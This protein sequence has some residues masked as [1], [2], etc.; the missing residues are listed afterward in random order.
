MRSFRLIG[1]RS[2]PIVMAG[3]L[4]FDPVPGSTACGLAGAKAWVERAKALATES[5]GPHVVK[6]YRRNGSGARPAVGPLGWVV[7][8]GTWRH[9]AAG[10]D[11]NEALLARLGERGPGVLDELDGC[12]AVAWWDRASGTLTVAPDHF[13]RLHVYGAE[14]PEGTYIGTSPVA[15]ARAARSVDPD[16]VA[17]WEMLATGVIYEDRSP[18]AGVKRLLGTHRYR[19]RDGRS[20]GADD[21]PLLP[22]REPGPS[23]SVAD[24]ADACREAVFEWFDRGTRFLPDL[25]GGMDSRL[26]AG[27]QLGAGLA[28]DVTVTG[29]PEEPDARVAGDLARRLGLNLRRVPRA[30][31]AHAQ[32]SWDAVLRAASRVEGTYDAAEYAAIAAV[33]EP[34]SAIGEF[35]VNGSGGEVYRN[36]WWDERHVGRT[37]GDAVGE[38][39]RRFAAAAIAPR[40]AEPRDA[41]RHFR[42]VLARTLEARAGDPMP[43]LFDHAYLHLR[44][45]C[46]QG[47]IASATNQIW[48]TISPLLLARPLSVLYRVPD[49]ERLHGR[50]FRSLMRSFPGPF[51]TTPLVTG[52][53]PME[54]ALTNFWRFVPGLFGLPAQYWGRAR[55]RFLRGRPRPDD[56]EAVRALMAAGAADFLRPRD[57]VLRPLLDARRL[58]EF[59]AVAIRE[60]TVPL[61]FVGRLVALEWALRE[62]SA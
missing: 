61:R 34:N 35:S 11:D 40:F 31:G 43:A 51:R 21:A 53:P 9:P 46:W 24:L 10:R 37:D 27:F 29:D 38:L 14:A 32:R 42:D 55:E 7:T 15:V 58:D 59:L 6:V 36:Y 4:A 19:F 54:P 45:Q 50:L 33:H 52:F 13:G 8:A 49:R 3:L 25:T 26:V 20:A 28:F 41:G 18:F 56:G 62:A 30:Q 60:G 2:R 47:A 23:A 22:P 12:Y 16:P 44:M 48:P 5:P 1:I 17:T 57:L 39:V